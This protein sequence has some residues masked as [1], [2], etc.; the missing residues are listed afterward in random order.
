[1]TSFIY[2]CVFTT[3]FGR[4]ELQDSK[5]G[6]DRV[7]MTTRRKRVPEELSHTISREK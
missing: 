6:N 7:M 1:M 3:E 2:I 4:L 5:F